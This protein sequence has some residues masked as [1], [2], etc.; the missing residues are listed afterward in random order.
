MSLGII[1]RLL[2]CEDKN[3]SVIFP[4]AKDG[5]A[6]YRDV[7]MCSA[8]AVQALSE[9]VTAAVVKH[10]ELYHL[11]YLSSRFRLIKGK[12]KNYVFDLKVKLKITFI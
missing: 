6:A 5:L 7:G 12:L 11:S 9:D 8:G 10:T 3:S 2:G 4:Y 1:L